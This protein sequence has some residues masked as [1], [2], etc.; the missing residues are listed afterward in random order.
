[1]QKDPLDSCATWDPTKAL[2]VPQPLLKVSDAIAESS[3]HGTVQYRHSQMPKIKAWLNLLDEMQLLSDLPLVPSPLCFPTP[4][5][6]S[7]WAEMSLPQSLDLV[8]AALPER[9][10]GQLLPFPPSPMLGTKRDKE[11][12]E[13][14]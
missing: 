4:G 14:G 6:S 9:L 2:F 8:S 12:P 13:Q 10:P 1:M 3:G 7:R 5:L 11:S